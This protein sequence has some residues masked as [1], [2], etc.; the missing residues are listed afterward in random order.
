[1]DQPPVQGM[2]RLRICGQKNGRLFIFVTD[3]L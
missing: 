3:C 1:M 2:D